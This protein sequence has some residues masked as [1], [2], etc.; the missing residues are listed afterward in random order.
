MPSSATTWC[1]LYLRSTRKISKY[2]SGCFEKRL[3]SRPLAEPRAAKWCFRSVIRVPPEARAGEVE[4]ESGEHGSGAVAARLALAEN[5]VRQQLPQLGSA[6]GHRHQDIQDPRLAVPIADPLAEA[7]ELVEARVQQRVVLAEPLGREIACLE[8]PRQVACRHEPGLERVVDAF[9]GQRVD[10]AGSLADQQGPFAK[11]G[12]PQ[13]RRAYRIALHRP[14]AAA[15]RQ[16]R[17]EPLR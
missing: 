11:G 6:I 15:A 1:S 16:H 9:A 7:K 3:V 13:E 5:D 2:R 10:Q 12:R 17:R 4:G 14:D 8:Q